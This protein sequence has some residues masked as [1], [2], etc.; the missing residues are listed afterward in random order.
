MY[1]ESVMV[2]TDYGKGG[3]MKKGYVCDFELMGI[4][5]PEE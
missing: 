4:G 3:Y 1:V 5:V 2:K